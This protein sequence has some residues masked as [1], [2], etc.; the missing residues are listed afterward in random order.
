MKAHPAKILTD[1]EGLSG[2]GSMKAKQQVITDHLDVPEFVKVV[3]YAMDP[4]KQFYLTTVP[5]LVDIKRGKKAATKM[6]K[7]GV[8]DAFADDADNQKLPWGQ[9]FSTMFELLD[10][11][12]SRDLP[13]NSS[14]AR[15]AVLKWAERCGEGTIECFQRII[16]KDL[17][18]GLGTKTFNKVNPGWIPTFDVQLAK[19]FDEKKLVFP[20][21]VDPKFDGSRCIAMVTYDGDGGGS[22]IYFSRNGNEFHNFGTFSDDLLRL[23]KGQGNVVVDCE[24]ISKHGF[25][26]LMR[27][28]T[29][30]DPNFD[31]SQLRLM[32]FDW[33]TQEAFETHEW[34]LTQEK[35]LS[36]LTALFKGFKSDKVQ[37]VETRIA[38]D[39]ADLTNIYQYW[40][41]A[42]LEGIIIKQPDGLY[43]F[44]RSDAW[45]KMKPEKT[46]D[47][48]IIGMELGDSRK[49]WAGKC[50]SL[51]V[52]RQLP[53]GNVIQ[54]NVAGGLDHQMHENIKQIGNDIQYT[55]PDGETIVLNGKLV[56][57]TF[58]C[59][60]EDG[61]L[62]FPRINRRKYPK[63]IRPDK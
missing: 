33:M 45:M 13:P 34:D 51:I 47:L 1:I 40:V 62:R 4:F 26:R 32:V 9:Q 15:D 12:A 27:V 18:C 3:R 24:A 43:D 58:D 44:S 46:E 48:K 53:D 14:A 20:C 8:R 6:A 19:P 49:Q 25:Q 61:S 42:G 16:R 7:K 17:R 55:T 35:R 31:P 10:K 60:T 50:G 39:M 5:G 54:V 52:E 56:E 2:S 30:F 11:L 28:P 57:V 36:E 63:I 29:N 41:D 22:V 21:Y 38:T 23:F 59:E 37:Q